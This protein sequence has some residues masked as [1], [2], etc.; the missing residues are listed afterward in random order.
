MGNRSSTYLHDVHE[1]QPRM[2]PQ[3]AAPASA[4]GAPPPPAGPSRPPSLTLATTAATPPIRTLRMPLC[5]AIDTVDLAATHPHSPLPSPA[6]PGLVDVW[7]VAGQSNSVGDNSAD[8]TDIPP[9]AQP[10]PGLVLS[11]DA[12]GTWRDAVPNIHLGVHGYSAMPSNGPGIPF[13][14]TLVSLGLSGRVGLVPCA[15]GA[16]NLFSDWRPSG[17]GG[18][19]GGGGRATGGGGGGGSTGGAG[20]SGPSG[21]AGS[22][23]AAGGACEGY[24]YAAMIARTK[25]ALAAPLPG[26][27]ACRLRGMIWVQGESDAEERWGPGPSEA[28]GAHL[29]AFVAAVRRDLA[30]HHTQLP[31]LMAVMAVR[32]RECFPFLPAVRAAQLACSAPGLVR[33][34]MAGFE[35]FEE[36]GPYHVHLTKDGAAAMGCA[37]GHAY[38]ASVVRAGLPRGPPTANTFG[39][40]P[41]PAP[42]A[43]G[44]RSAR[45]SLAGTASHPS[46]TAAA[47]AHAAAGAGAC[48]GAGGVLVGLAAVPSPAGTPRSG[49]PAEGTPRAGTP[50]AEAGAGAGAG[51]AVQG[52]LARGAAEAEEEERPEG[53]QEREGPGAEAPAAA[54]QLAEKVEEVEEGG[55]GE[56]EAG[57]EPGRQ[58]VTEAAAGERQP[59]EEQPEEGEGQGGDEGEGQGGEEGEGQRV[60]KERRVGHPG[61]GG[62]LGVTG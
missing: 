14:R 52:V 36:Y 5:S 57:P 20:G 32:K 38:Y 53:A 2:D 22:G 48:A 26:G 33:V 55:R 30:G 54:A 8:G 24:C 29:G 37:M 13:A 41:A 50:R 47:P 40:V 28:Y 59:A 51:A 16:T 21:V 4:E 60:R 25:A 12:S 9:A 3:D 58:E 39:V 19:G 45:P 6:A 15:K 17:G 42:S 18:G 62:D 7:I 43:A 31:I 56:A 35:F 23:A 44:G 27:G 49:T 11:Y 10:L 46:T 61:A 34:D 1:P